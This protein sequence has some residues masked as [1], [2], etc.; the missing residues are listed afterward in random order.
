VDMTKTGSITVH[1]MTREEKAR[2]PSG[3]GARPSIPGSHWPNRTAY[4]RLPSWR[5]VSMW[6]L[7]GWVGSAASP[8]PWGGA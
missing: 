3:E 7:G 8:T 6:N 5:H 2:V 1:T 4:P